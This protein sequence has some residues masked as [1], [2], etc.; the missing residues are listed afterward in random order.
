MNHKTDRL[1]S[2]KWGIF[3]HYLSHIQNLGYDTSWNDCVNEFDVKRF[4]KDIHK[5]GAGY[6]IFTTMQGARFMCAPNATFDNISGY[7]AGEACSKR[8]LIAEIADELEKYDIDLMLYFT[9]DGPYK[10]EKA[11]VAF[12]YTRKGFDCVTE[13]FVRNWAAV[14]EE[15]ATRYGDKVKGWWVDGCYTALGYNDDLLKIYKDA[16]LKGNPNAV[17]SFNNGTRRADW[18]NEKYREILNGETNPLKIQVML[19]DAALDGNATAMEAFIP[20]GVTGYSKHDD[21]TA[22]EAEKFVFYPKDPFI[23]GARWHILSF[24]G[25]PNP[26]KYD[27]IWG[28]AAWC[29]GGVRYSGSYMKK[30]VSEVNSRGGIVSVDVKLN[31]DGSIDKEHIKTLMEI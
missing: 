11:G 21:Y 29:T 27:I 25:E 30:Y 28:E 20:H 18:F 2:K 9:G 26:E 8:D 10:D 14:L 24:L 16:V 22:G 1:F 5:S 31:R 6:V 7:T 17:I 23:N 13:D 4:A 3:T 12:G 19:S 15:Y